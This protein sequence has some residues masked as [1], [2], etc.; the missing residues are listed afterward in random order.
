MIKQNLPLGAVIF[1]SLLMLF[2]SLKVTLFRY[3]NFEYGKF[4]LG[5]MSQMVYNTLHGNFMEVT[6][7]FGANMPRWGMSHVDPF[8]VVFV[9]FYALFPD[10]RVLIVAQLALVIFSSILI[11]FIGLKVIGSKVASALIALAYL[12]YPALGYVLAWTG[13]HGVTAIIPFFLGSFLMFEVMDSKKDFSRKNLILFYILIFITLTGKEEISLIILMY[14]L[15]LY[16][17][18]RQKK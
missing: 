5:N 6:D 3:Q 14:G 15:Y 17:F 4:D 9:P 8:L 16:F 13:F 12:F 10:A 11:Y 18:R 1:V 2:M 7:Y